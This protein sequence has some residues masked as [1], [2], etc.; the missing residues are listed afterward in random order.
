MLRIECLVQNASENH[1]SSSVRCSVLSIECAL[2][3]VK[4]MKS[5][6]QCKLKSVQC[7][8]MCVITEHNYRSFVATD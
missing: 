4:Y 6:V 1:A 7:V 2:F 3:R 8:V 5:S